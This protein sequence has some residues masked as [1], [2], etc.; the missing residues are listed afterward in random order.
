MSQWGWLVAAT[1]SQRRTALENADSFS[2]LLRSDSEETAAH[3]SSVGLRSL[4]LILSVEINCFH[5]TASLGLTTNQTQWTQTPKEKTYWLT[6]AVGVWE[7][8]F[9]NISE[10]T[11]WAVADSSSVRFSQR[12]LE[13]A[14][15]R[16]QKST[17]FYIQSS[18]C[19]VKSDRIDTSQGHLHIIPQNTEKTGTMDICFLCL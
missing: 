15:R 8:D 17:V 19:K 10:E 13:V 2:S 4:D 5:H 14:S 16:Q 12:R 18:F 9:V 11:S 1:V 3:M 7:R 6:I